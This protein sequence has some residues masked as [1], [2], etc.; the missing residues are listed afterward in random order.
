MNVLRSNYYQQY[1]LRLNKRLV[2]S[3]P[4]IYQGVFQ[5]SWELGAP[6]RI[7]TGM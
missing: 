1:S 3:R 4:D 7:L 2:E 5:R 6:L